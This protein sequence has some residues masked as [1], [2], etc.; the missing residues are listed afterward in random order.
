MILNNAT[1]PDRVAERLRL[2]AISDLFRLLSILLRLPTDE[3]VC[4]VSEEVIEKD[5]RQIAGEIG[6]DDLGRQ[7]TKEALDM[8]A[9]QRVEGTLSLTELRIEFTRLF[10]HP[11]TPAIHICECLFL[12]WSRNPNGKPEE[13]PRLFI[14]PAAFD[15][16]QHYRKAGFIRSPSINEPADSMAT[17]MEF[18]YNLFAAKA[19]A[20]DENNL[21]NLAFLDECIEGFLRDHLQKWAVGFFDQCVEKSKNA[22]YQAVGLV[23]GALVKQL[24]GA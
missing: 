8:L 20:L 19:V 15:A 14:S 2:V 22:L 13:A 4:A 7:A 24:A 17:Q 9:K 11:D 10:S 12:F 3:V 1:T 18:L 16:E 5:L 21:E 23:G 6:F